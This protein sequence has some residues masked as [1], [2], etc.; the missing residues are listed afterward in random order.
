MKKHLIAAAVAAAVAA[1][2]MAQN[3]TVSGLIDVAPHVTA[4]NTV[5]AANVKASGTT[6]VSGWST[7]NIAF[8]ASEDL[9]GGMKASATISSFFD[10]GS[11]SPGNGLADAA[12]TAYNTIGGRDRFIKLEGGFGAIQFG[13]FAP[14]INGYCGYSCAGGTNN[15]AGTTDSGSSDLVVGTLSG[16]KELS[17]IA[18][19]A[20]RSNNAY[21][22]DGD[23]AN[24]NMGAP[25]NT[26]VNAAHMEHQSGVFEFTT[27]TV[28]GFNAVLT[29]INGKNDDSGNAG[30]DKATQHGI[31]VN[32]S[33]GPL[34]AS[35][36]TGTRK[37]EIELNTVESQTKASIN[38]FGLSYDLGMAKLFAS[39]ATRKDK[40]TDTDNNVAEVTLGNVKV[41]TIGLQ[42]PMGAVTFNASM[43]QGKNKGSLSPADLG[44]TDNAEDRKL[45]GHQISARYALSKRTFAYAVTGVNKDSRDN[46]A[47]D[48]DDFKRSQT[49]IGFVHSF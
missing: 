19:R 34:A 10:S 1:P 14:T 44:D 3:V 21:S 35:L 45:K 24:R 41:N 15:N 33:A 17:A 20:L 39:Y 4:K 28:S 5:G 27:P 11:T 47:L 26:E 23:A 32:Y 31:R 18:A 13:R 6:G 38:W 48:N 49:Q 7:S 12:G 43:Y 25:G 40:L 42:V 30:T 9:G 2:V 46:T 29:Y 36:A 16:R 8:T 37:S 22:F